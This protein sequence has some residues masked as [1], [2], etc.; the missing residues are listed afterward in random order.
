M[1]DPIGSMI[2]YGIDTGNYQPFVTGGATPI[3]YAAQA[4]SGGAYDPSVVGPYNGG[5]SSTPTNTYV[6]P[7]DPYARWGGR[8]QYDNLVN[9]MRSSRDMITGSG[10][11]AFADAGNEFDTG[12]RGLVTK[13]RQGQRAIDMNRQNIALNKMR[14]ISDL[15][16]SIRQGLQSGSVK[17]SNMN[18]LD[19]SGAEG[20]A[21]AYS[22]FGTKQRGGIQNEA[23][24][25]NREQDLAQGDLDVEREEK[26]RQLRLYKDTQTN[27]I[28]RDVGDKLRVLDEEAAGQGLME[29]IEID[30]LK[31]EVVSEG[32]AR[33]QQIDAWLSSELGGI[34]AMSGDEV[35][36]TA[37]ALQQ[38]GAGPVGDG[39]SFESDP[40]IVGGTAPVV[41]LPIFTRRRPEFS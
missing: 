33:L 3:P 6:A 13:V 30:R 2:R 17:L 41:N 5:T 38:G 29:R 10:R 22:Q 8:A 18:A 16:G 1:A 32:L 34:K 23:F 24:L 19:S 21:R 31:N 14:S 28:S 35:D 20:M 37:F 39:F 25:Q 11:S 26:A 40:G 27:K 7:P 4:V 36:A 9:Q 12:A 15:V